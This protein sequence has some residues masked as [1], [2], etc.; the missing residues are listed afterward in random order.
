MKK[1]SVLLLAL[2]A[3]GA[4]LPACALAGTRRNRGLGP[5]RFDG[6][7]VE[8]QESQEGEEAQEGAEGEE[9]EQE[10]EEAEAEAEEEGSS[11]SSSRRHHDAGHK[12]SSARLTSLALTHGGIAALRQAHPR[13]SNVCFSFTLSATAKVQ[14]VLATQSHAG[15]HT[16]W[17]TVSQLTV[18]GKRGSNVAHFAGHAAL[19]TGS[20]RLT[21]T[22][23]H[24][25]QRTIAFRV[26]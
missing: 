14:A 20:D 4:W 8:G 19:I 16:S 13:T 10:A 11:G 23:T 6:A 7:E 24:G 3:L 12:G 18:S 21:L 15:G 1:I 26:K 9:S 5:I 22:P 17:H 2:L 25:S